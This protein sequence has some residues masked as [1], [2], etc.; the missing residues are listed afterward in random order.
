MKLAIFQTALGQLLRQQNSKDPLRGMQLDEGQRR[1]FDGLRKTAGFKCYAG[2]QRSWCMGRSAKSA[3]LTL[4]VL[5]ADKRQFLLDQW[6]EAGGGTHSFYEVE[7][8]SF[9]EFISQQLPDPSHE[10]TV[11][12]LEQA[13]LRANLG[14]AELPASPAASDASPLINLTRIVRRGAYAQLVCVH[15]DPQALLVSIEKNE[16]LPPL[17]ANLVHLMFS[18]GLPHLW[19]EP[20]TEELDIWKSLATPVPAAKLIDAGHSPDTIERLWRQG[21]IEYPK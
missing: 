10:L 20:S 12:H 3:R 7:S 21:T 17:S 16:P 19:H 8:E 9:L 13:T 1:Y 14:I 2:I 5:A 6:V 15:G 18:P 11:C 4:S